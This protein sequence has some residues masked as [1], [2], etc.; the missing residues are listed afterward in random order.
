MME[1]LFLYF[2][3]KQE[4]CTVFV[5]LVEVS[6]CP[7]LGFRIEAFTVGA[8][9]CVDVVTTAISSIPFTIFGIENTVVTI[10]I[11][12]PARWPTFQTM[13]IIAIGVPSTEII[14]ATSSTIIIAVSIVV[15]VIAPLICGPM[16][17]SAAGH[18]WFGGGGG[19]CCSGC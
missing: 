9:V 2:W 19:G 18:W 16:R 12:M 8:V 13:T 7:G 15:L 14:E 1:C 17:G 4:I 5:F 10:V 11:S 3:P 6:L